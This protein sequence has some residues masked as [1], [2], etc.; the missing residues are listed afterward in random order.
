MLSLT[1]S[2]YTELRSVVESPLSNC[3][4]NLSVSEGSML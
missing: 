3:C 4:E 1:V 2:R